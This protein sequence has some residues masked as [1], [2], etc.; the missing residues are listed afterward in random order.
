MKRYRKTMAFVNKHINNGDAIIDLG[1]DNDLSRLMR[2]GGY[3]VKNTKFDLDVDYHAVSFYNVITA[4]EIFEHMF[5]PFNVLNA[6]SGTLIA[7]VPLKLWFAK[8]Y[9]NDKDP[10]DCHYHEFEKKQFDHLL[11][12]TGW[13]I[14][15]SETWTDPHRELG[16]RPI[17][18]LFYKRYYIVYATK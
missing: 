14:K 5:A 2:R 12:R 8:A 1:A 3:I 18:R 11:K 13:T 7:S 16:I 15:D 9:W 17:L 10:L 4:F 6:S